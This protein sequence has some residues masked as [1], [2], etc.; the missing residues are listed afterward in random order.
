M[1]PADRIS[2]LPPYL[3]S[4]LDKKL[5][6]KKAQGV[7]VISLGVGDPD[8]PTP[9]HVVEA[10]GKAVRDPTNHRYP[11][12]FG[13]PGFRE[14]VAGWYLTRHGVR[15]DP[16]TQVMALIGSKEGLGHLPVAFVDPGQPPPPGVR[17]QRPNAVD[18][19]AQALADV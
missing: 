14:A 12:Y 4:E 13:S 2:T 10:M 5:A 17:A 6:S 11:S 9:P 15:L 8:M 3:F 19:S 16:Q 18:D 1:K 7:D